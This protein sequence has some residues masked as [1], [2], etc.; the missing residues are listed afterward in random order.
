[1]RS[2]V[3]L[4]TLILSAALLACSPGATTT[5]AQP[6][7]GW[8]IESWDDGVITVQH[9]G[10]IYKAKCYAAVMVNERI[11]PSAGDFVPS[12]ERP[13]DTISLPCGL[14]ATEFV[15]RRVQPITGKQ[16]E[17]D[18]NIVVMDD[19]ALTL[20]LRSWKEHSPWTQ[21]NYRIQSVAA[22]RR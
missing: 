20:I 11:S 16:R 15:G 9:L 2:P 12:G 22:M 7:Q 10:K 21:E 5:A 8:F 6:D 13:L 19:P 14:L 18:G 3:L 1:M 4:S 17:N